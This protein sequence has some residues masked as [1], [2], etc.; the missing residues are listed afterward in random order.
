MTSVDFLS[1]FHFASMETTGMA[2]KSEVRRWIR[3]GSVLFN[4]ERVDERELIN[5]PII[6]VVLH[7]KSEKKVTLW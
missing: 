6:S 7:P 1:P 4:G 2:T 5:F 3:Q